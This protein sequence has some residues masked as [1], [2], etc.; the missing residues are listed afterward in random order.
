MVLPVGIRLNSPK[1]S[2]INNNYNSNN[3]N[4]KVVYTVGKLFSKGEFGA[5][6]EV[7]C[8]R[9][10]SI[11]NTSPRW[12]V[13]LTPVPTKATKKQTSMLEVAHRLLW[14]ENLLYSHHFVQYCGTALPKIP[15]KHEKMHGLDLFMD[16]IQG[17]YYA[18][19]TKVRNGK[20]RHPFFLLR[21]F[22]RLYR[23]FKTRSLIFV[24]SF[25]RH[26]SVLSYI[27]L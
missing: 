19:E 20:L 21:S 1:N 12:V 2:N 14:V 18:K 9:N 13:K 24:F 23:E 11:D 7:I 25:I 3:S 10:D 8:T 17:T 4:E 5:V 6:H 27:C 26:V 16:N 15:G 22:G